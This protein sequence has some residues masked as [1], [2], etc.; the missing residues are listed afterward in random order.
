MKDNFLAKWLNDE[1]ESSELQELQKTPE[2]E[3]YNKIISTLDKLEAPAF[4]EKAA[5]ASFK[6][7][8][9]ATPQIKEEKE[10]KVIK[11]N[12]WKPILRIAAVVVLAVGFYTYFNTLDTSVATDLAQ[13]SEITLP[14]NSEV[15][16]NAGSEI[17]FNKN[18]WNE[19]R[20][21]NL[22]GE[23]FFKVAKGQKF[24]VVTT[25]GIV[26]VLGTQF[27]V[28]NREGLFQV[29][30][31]EGLVSV[32]H[33]GQVT[34]LPAGT[35]F[36]VLNGEVVSKESPTTQV[37]SWTINE[38][39]FKSMPLGIVIAELER[40]HNVVIETQNLDLN[41]NFT[42]NFSNNDVNLALKSISIP[43]NLI[44]DIQDKKV[45]LYAENNK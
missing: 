26:S 9:L 27:N 4:D 37:P 10:T 40:Q 41:K 1:L 36:T 45:I 24:D 28:N 2:F 30:C 32:A 11:M 33:K 23:A 15:I 31:Y 8:Y 18:S 43:L 13:M 22:K 34:K 25:D 42:G 5:F 21:V 29:T 35:A 44:F 12:V 19:N 17:S 7:N 14:D 20:E 3:S 38:S 39:S 16:V 6:S